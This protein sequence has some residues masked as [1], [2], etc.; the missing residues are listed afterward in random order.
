[1]LCVR[2]ELLDTWT[3]YK[4]RPA[5][6]RGSRPLGDRHAEPRGTRRP[7]RRGRLPG[8]GRP[9]LRR[10]GRRRRGATRSWPA[11]ARSARTSASS[12]RGSSRA[13]PASRASGSGA[14]PTT[15]ASTSARRRSR[16]ALGDQHPLEDGERARRERGIFVWDGHYYAI[17]RDGAAR[18]CSS[19][20]APCGS[21]SATTTRRRGGPGARGPRRPGLTTR[22][23]NLAGLP[24]VQSLGLPHS[25]ERDLHAHP[26]P[27][28][29]RLPRLA[30]RDALLEPRPRGPRR[31]QLPAPPRARRGRHR[32]AHADPARPARARR[33]VEGRHRQGDRR[34][35]G[36]P[37]RLGRH[38][39]AC[40]ASSSPRRSCTTARCRR[41]R[42]R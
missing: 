3:P 40:S 20:A 10:P 11:S 28:R 13:S 6:R 5:P 27:R 31:R 42:T 26:D 41:R 15:T 12:P 22:A 33:R 4:L 39:S 29:R 25:V 37:Q 19:P 30:D 36:R 7:D 38:R 16:S 2:R 35:R 32:L 18:A 21:A 1:M 14:S 9:D 34:H 8:R 17:D 23:G 24:P